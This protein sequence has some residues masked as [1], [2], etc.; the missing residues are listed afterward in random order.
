MV[1]T[2]IR[3]ADGHC[4][5]CNRSDVRKDGKHRHPCPYGAEACRRLARRG[6]CI[7]DL[8][9][10]IFPIALSLLLGA[11]CVFTFGSAVMFMVDSLEV[12]PWW[13]ATAI[14]IVSSFVSIWAL[15]RWADG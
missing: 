14:G 13:F 5:H 11:I 9:E 15:F 10:R 6:K 1:G 2:N 12:G 4:P 7:M 8:P 3:W